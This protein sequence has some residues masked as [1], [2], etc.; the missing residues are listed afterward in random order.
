ML[1]LHEFSFANTDSVFTGTGSIQ[2]NRLLN[3][4]LIYRFQSE[5]LFFNFGVADANNMQITVSCK[6]FLLGSSGKEPFPDI[7]KLVLQRQQ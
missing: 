5:P 4:I 3:D 2:F 1:K 7:W 6:R